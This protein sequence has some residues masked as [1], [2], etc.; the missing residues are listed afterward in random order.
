[1]QDSRFSHYMNWNKKKEKCCEQYVKCNCH[2]QK[3]CEHKVE[4][5]KCKHKYDQYKWEHKQNGCKCWQKNEPCQR[6]Q[7]HKHCHCKKEEKYCDEEDYYYEAE[8]AKDH[9]CKGCICH[10]LKCLSTGAFVD[11]ILAGGGSFAGIYFISLDP[12]TCCATFFEVAG[13]AASPLI[14]D[15]QQIIAIRSANLA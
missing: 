15:C 9:H 8:H 5:C 12:K 10:Q 4:E 7:K 11:V 1:M 14:I 3:K 6:E 2:L 13:A